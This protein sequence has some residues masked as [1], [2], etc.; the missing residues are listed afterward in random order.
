M[1]IEPLQAA[2]AAINQFADPNADD[3]TLLV[4]AK[5]RGLMAGYDA[6]WR[7]A[8]YQATAV[9]RVIDGPLCNVETGA[10]SQRFTIAGKLDVEAVLN[11]RTFVFDHKTTSED[12]TDPNSMYWRQLVVEGQPTH[13]LLLKW[14]RGEKPDGAVWDVVRKP[15]ISPKKLTKAERTAIVADRRYCGRR[16]SIESLESLQRD[17]RE[18]LELYEARLSHD[19]TIERPDWYFQRRSIPRLDNEL[20]EHARGLW[21]FGQELLAERARIRKAEREGKEFLP[22]KSPN[23]CILYNSPCEFLG[24]CSG[25]DTITSDRW[26]KKASVHPELEGMAGEDA[27]TNSRIRTF[28]A[29]K[30]KH[31]YK[32]ELGVERQEEEEREAIYFGNCLHAALEAWWRCFLVPSNEVTNYDNCA[33]ATP[34]TD[35]GQSY[36]EAELLS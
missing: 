19:C 20:L 5:C 3:K 25:H 12:I 23:A 8:G 15:S 28:D 17:D 6:R 1:N 9:E 16:I 32:Y 2:I 10:K 18:T 36:A 35:V 7:S 11:G 13:Y 34:A 31:F 4:L 26:K 29:C 33:A 21:D 30:R 24:V 14:L 22:R 27:L